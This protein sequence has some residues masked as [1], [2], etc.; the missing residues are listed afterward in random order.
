MGVEMVVLFFF[1]S[2]RRH[3]RCALV[4]GVQ[5]C[6]LPISMFVAIRRDVFGTV[7]SMLQ[8]EG[9]LRWIHGWTSFPLPNRFLGVTPETAEAYAALPLE[10]KFAVRR[11]EESRVGKECVSTCR[12][13]WSQYH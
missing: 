9:V 6:A 13:R 4:T 10:A 7:N 2:R 12:S 5:T 3:T 1:S 8:H 11:S